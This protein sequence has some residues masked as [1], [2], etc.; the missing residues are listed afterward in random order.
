MVNHR[1]DFVI[2]LKGGPQTMLV[3]ALNVAL[4]LFTASGGD[5]CASLVV[6]LHHQLVRAL[7]REVK[8]LDKNI[9]HVRHQ[10][11]WVIPH[12]RNPRTIKE[13]IEIEF[14]IGQRAHDV[15]TVL[16]QKTAWKYLL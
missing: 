3:Q 15:T 16:K 14:G 5:R 10:I 6:D 13:L 12:D 11:Y 8:E 1:L 2:A 7:G 9:G 4:H